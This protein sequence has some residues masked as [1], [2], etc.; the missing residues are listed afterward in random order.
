MQEFVAEAQA[1]LNNKLGLPSDFAVCDFGLIF[2]TKGENLI[3]RCM[4]SD[5][6]FR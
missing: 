5:K 1:L 2:E 3:E 4:Y 6:I